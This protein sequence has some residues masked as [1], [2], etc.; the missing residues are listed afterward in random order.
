M[1]A[2]VGVGLLIAGIV[3]SNG[4]AGPRQEGAS[5]AEGRSEEDTRDWKTVQSRKKKKRTRRGII[6]VSG[7]AELLASLPD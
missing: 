2:I 6:K 7:G 1:P 4:G 3:L 5:F